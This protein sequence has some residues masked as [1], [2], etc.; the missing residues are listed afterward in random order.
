MCLI[1]IK[2]TS[3]DLAL[4]DAETMMAGIPLVNLFSEP[5]YQKVREKWC[6][7]IFGLGYMKY[8]S[9]CEV[10][11]NETNSNL[12]A[13]F[14][15]RVDKKDWPFQIVEVQEPGRKR[16]DEYKGFANGTIKSIP[17]IPEKG[18][19]EG[20]DWLKNGIE[21]KIKKNYA[22]S[23]NLNLLVY[24]NFTARQLDCTQLR[25][26]LLDF[27]GKFAS[28][29]LITTTHVCSLFSTQELGEIA[30]WYEVRDISSY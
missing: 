4:K 28:I 9:H 3:P 27:K 13:D 5:R 22:G 10:G 18:H 2:F 7:G 21:K 12:D 1:N 11:I 8:V 20:P 26:T 23:E 14:F 16:S 17:Y 30:V 19:K 6:A 25:N 15:L 24:A 29:W